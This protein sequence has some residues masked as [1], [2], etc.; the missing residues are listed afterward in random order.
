MKVRPKIVSITSKGQATIPADLRKKYNLQN[1]A[2]IVDTDE[3]ILIR[4]PPTLEQEMGSLKKILRK[5]SNTLLRNARKKD[6]V[7]EK[8]MEGLF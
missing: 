1:K 4:S 7:K 8:E 2:I 6:R 5:E 3:G